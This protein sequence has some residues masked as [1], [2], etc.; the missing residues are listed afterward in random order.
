MDLVRTEWPSGPETFSECKTLRSFGGGG[1]DSPRRDYRLVKNWRDAG[2]QLQKLAD[3]R[4]PLSREEEI[5]QRF[6]GPP[7]AVKKAA[8]G[9]FRQSKLLEDG[10]APPAL[11]DVGSGGLVS[12]EEAVPETLPPA[13]RSDAPP[14]KRKVLKTTLFSTG[15]KTK[16]E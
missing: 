9:E 6:V 8:Y 12:V 13:A 1:L 3:I 15:K 14:A 10:V 11:E 5:E 16:S 2:R 7:L 4:K